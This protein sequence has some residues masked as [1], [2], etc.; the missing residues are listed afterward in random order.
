[1]NRQEISVE[2]HETSSVRGDA[3]CRVAFI[4]A[5]SMAREHARAFGDIPGVE[6]VGIHSRTRARAE[7]LAEEMG[8]G[9]V[10]DSIE[11]M[12]QATRA[13]LVVVAVSELAANPISRL[14]F[15]HDWV[16]LMEKPAGIDVADA[17]EIARAARDGGRRAYVGLNRRF[18]SS[19]QQAVAD[20]S[21]R[22]GPRLIQVLDQQ[23]PA[24]ARSAGRP[25]RVVDNWMFANSIH[26]I[27]YL[28][29]FGR[30]RIERVDPVVPWNPE[31]PGFV[32]GR[33]TF[34][35]GDIGLYEG[36]W[37]GPG[38][39]SA[40]ITTESRRWELRPLESGAYQNRGERQLR[41]IDSNPWDLAF[42]AGFRAQ[43]Q[44]AIAAVHGKSTLLPSLDEGVQ[45]MRL[46]R[47]LFAPEPTTDLQ[48]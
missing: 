14:A 27:D 35:S 43:A 17:E 16:V 29:V 24:A 31:D 1:M 28:R 42:K 19:T 18:Y 9:A 3:G 44:E 32:V 36:I 25:A 21:T 2:N 33:V 45:T 38:P 15:E 48:G 11:G 34:E 13:D 5:G 7:K 22:E 4:G 46:A 47:A 10:Y 23:D 8:I 41:P 40:A 37:N 39:W 6:L 26:T 12:Y 30:G 20:L